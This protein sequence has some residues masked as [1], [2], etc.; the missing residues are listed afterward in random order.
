MI[1]IRSLRA[2]LSLAFAGVAL[3]ALA[4]AYAIV[5][6]S[7]ERSLVNAKLDQLASSAQ[8]LSNFPTGVPVSW[9]DFVSAAAET[10][11]ARVALLEPVGLTALPMSVLSDSRE[12]PD[13]DL[14]ND[15]IAAGVVTSGTEQRGF[16]SRDGERFAEVALPV[17]QGGRVLVFTAPLEDTLA[18][19]HLVQRRVLLAGGA[20]LLVALLLGVTAASVF[21]ERLRRLERAA[22]RIAGGTLDEPVVDS[23]SDEVGQLADAFEHMRRRLAQL[24]HA[25]REFVANASHELRTPIFSLAGFL[26]LLASEE[27]DDET[28][29]DFIASMREQV[30][31]LTVLASELLD[32]SRLDAGQLRTEREVVDLAALAEGIAG[33][34]RAVA[35]ASG[36]ALEVGVDPDAPHALAD[37]ERVR[38]VARALVENALRHTAGGTSVR[39]HV[40]RFRRGAALSVEDDGPGIAP[41]HQEHV[42]ERFYRIDGTRA[43]GSG[44]GLAIARELTELMG[45]RLDLESEPG[46]TVFRLVFPAVASTAATAAGEQPAERPAAVG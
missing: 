22:E 1:R 33:E 6:P 30:E 18:T 34:F 43:S 9:G 32:L 14:A 38:Q 37:R 24:E 12:L 21:A 7:L 46:R 40:G 35:R 5:V 11:N 16:V 2:R 15:P 27:L 28:R 39:L 17:A 41:E 42:F 45:A 29:D 10:T 36:H 20:A 19:V 8:G 13:D 4:I 3:I 31:R 23:G 44:L 25:R 26:E